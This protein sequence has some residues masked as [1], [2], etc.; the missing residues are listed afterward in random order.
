MVLTFTQYAHTAAPPGLG[1]QFSDPTWPSHPH[2]GGESQALAPS[3]GGREVTEAEAGPGLLASMSH[4]VWAG[5]GGPSE[6]ESFHFGREEESLVFRVSFENLWEGMQLGK[7]PNWY[8]TTSKIKLMR[9][10]KK[11]IRHLQPGEDT[12]YGKGRE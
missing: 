10:R 8:G 11:T 9:G 3:Q 5:G 6:W 12:W 7:R 4:R 1:L 2:G